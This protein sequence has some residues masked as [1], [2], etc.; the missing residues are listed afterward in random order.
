LRPAPVTIATF[1]V[2][3]LVLAMTSLSAQR[4]K[5]DVAIV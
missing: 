3:S 1:P 5:I 4:C 2:S